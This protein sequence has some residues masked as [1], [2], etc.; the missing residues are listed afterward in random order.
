MGRQKIRF[1]TLRTWSVTILIILLIILFFSW[2]S[3]R[4]LKDR[5]QAVEVG[6]V[7]STV[8]GIEET[9][10]VVSLGG[11]AYTPL[12]VFYRGITERKRR[13]AD[14]HEPGGSI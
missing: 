14:E 6:F 8:G 4:F 5:S 2:K 7:Q 12:W 11:L 10:D 3:Y 9:S 1:L 13:Q